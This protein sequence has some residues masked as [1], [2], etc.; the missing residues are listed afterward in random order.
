MSDYRSSDFTVVLY[1]EGGKSFDAHA[2]SSYDTSPLKRRITGKFWRN[3][4]ACRVYR[5]Y[6]VVGKSYSLLDLNTTERSDPDYMFP[7]GKVLVQIPTCC[8]L[9]GA[10][11]SIG[12]GSRA[13][14]VTNRRQVD[15]LKRSLGSHYQARFFRAPR[16]KME[17][18]SSCQP[19]SCVSL[20]NEPGNS[21]YRQL[22][23]A[24]QEVDNP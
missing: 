2:R 22:A 12:C 9:P 1:G 4:S 6:G 11:P 20:S 19:S 8:R 18:K 3:F 14:L 23:A 15:Q 13:K 17:T 5:P 24:L 10:W 16:T 21:R 7:T